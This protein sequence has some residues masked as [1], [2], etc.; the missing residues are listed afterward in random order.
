MLSKILNNIHFINSNIE[1]CLEVYIMYLSIFF[2]L[3]NLN[4]LHS[5]HRHF[6]NLKEESIRIVLYREY[7]L[8]TNLNFFMTASQLKLVWLESTLF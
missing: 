8:E 7:F 1:Y 6:Q 4:N 2:L 5:L 3:V